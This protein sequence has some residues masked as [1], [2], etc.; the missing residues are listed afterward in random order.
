MLVDFPRVV[1]SC[2]FL[3]FL[4]SPD[5][6]WMLRVKAVVCVYRQIGILATDKIN[7]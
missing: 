6:G 4:S 3:P 5:K 7:R 2:Q 1:V